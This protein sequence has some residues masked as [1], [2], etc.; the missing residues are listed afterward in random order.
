MSVYHEGKKSMS[1]SSSALA[2]IHTVLK[3]SRLLEHCYSPL[4]QA[5]SFISFCQRCFSSLSLLL[6][7]R[8]NFHHPL[9]DMI[10]KSFLYISHF[11]VGLLFH[12]SF[13]SICSFIPPIFF[14]YNSTHVEVYHF[15]KYIMVYILSQ[16]GISLNVLSTVA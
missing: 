9:R 14:S 15:I 4:R 8:L 16:Y 6:M 2:K 11:Y 3:C 1:C 5:I 7:S 12:I 13:L 10:W